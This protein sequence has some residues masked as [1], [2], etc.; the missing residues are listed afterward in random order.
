MTTIIAVK[1]DKGITFGADSR[2]TTGG[3]PIRDSTSKIFTNDGI[4]FAGSGSARVCDVV[5]FM[6]IPARRTYE[7]EWSLDH[8]IHRTFVPAIRNALTEEQCVPVVDS[9]VS[10][11]SLLLFSVEGRLFELHS[12]LAILENFDGVFARGSGGAFALGALSA[13]ASVEDALRIA[14]THDIYSGEPFDIVELNNA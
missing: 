7:P 11:E 14:A 13:G 10:T 4:T 2:T 1:T 3:R 5:R 9:E 6:D 12:D 8:W